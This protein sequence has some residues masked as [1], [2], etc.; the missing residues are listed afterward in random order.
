LTLLAARLVA[1]L[2]CFWNFALFQAVI[3]K[4]DSLAWGT[5]GGGTTGEAVVTEMMAPV[6]PRWVVMVSPSAILVTEVVPVAEA[7]LPGYP[8]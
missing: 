2:S 4:V 7:P 5:G 1:R 6:L 8:A 3:S